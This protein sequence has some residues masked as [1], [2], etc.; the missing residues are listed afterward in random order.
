MPSIRQDSGSAER[1]AQKQ[2]R[3]GTAT[4]KE[5][6][7]SKL[8]IEHL[9]PSA[10]KP[11]T[12]NARTHSKKQIRQIADSIRAFGFTNPILIDDDRTIL[13]GH[14]RL[15]AARL[16]GLSVVRV[17]WKAVAFS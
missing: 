11:S 7:L 8:E 16:L 6:L 14:G 4:K 9:A 13:A 10:L 3:G 12:R 15:A 17:F 2:R 1:R 5:A